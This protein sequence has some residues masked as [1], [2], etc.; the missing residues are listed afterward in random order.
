LAIHC[1][2]K[3][4][5]GIYFSEVFGFW[6]AHSSF[7]EKWMS[8]SETPISA[9]PADPYGTLLEMS[10]AM[11]AHTSVDELVRE[12]GR[13]LHNLLDF[14]YLTLMI[15][16]DNRDVMLTHTVHTQQPGPV[17]DP[18]YSMEQSPSA[19]VWRTQEPLVVGDLDQENR[20]PVVMKFFRQNGVRSFCIV[21]LTTATRRIG[22]LTFGSSHL[23]AYDPSDLE[24][25]CLVA[26]QVA[27][28]VENAINYQVARELQNDLLRERDRLKMLLDIN[29]AVTSNLGLAELLRAIASS[30]RTAIQ[31]DAAYVSMLE[32]N[33]KSLRVRGLDYPDPRG[34]L[35]EG[36]LIPMEGSISGRVFHS[37]APFI[38]GKVPEGLGREPLL[39]MQ[40]EQF[41]SGYFV[42][43][44]RDGRT[45]GLLH[46]AD[47]SPDFFTKADG[48]LLEQIARQLAIALDNALKYDEAQQSRGQIAEQARYL[49][50]ELRREHNF[51]E[52]LGDSAELRKV[53]SEVATVAPTGSTVLIQ[54]ETGTGKE[55]IARA[56]HNL[57][58]SRENI[59]VKLNCAAIPSGLL[60]SELFGHERGAFTGAIAQKKGRFELAD[61]GTLFLDEIGDIPLELQP[62]LLRV[63]QEQEFERLGSSHSIHV[64]VRLIAATN[65]DLAK[66]VEE[67]EFR[68]D[69]YYRLNV[70]PISL[71]P[72]RERRE[73]IPILAI[74]FVETFARRIGQPIHKVPDEVIESLK[75]YSWPGNIRELQN[76]IERAVILSKDG[77]LRTPELQKEPA[78]V[79][80]TTES[81]QSSDPEKPKTLVEA[82]REY[83]TQILRKANWVLSGRDGAAVKLGIPRTTL[84][85][86]MRQLGIPRRPE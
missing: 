48:E 20:Y 2:L 1:A 30:V 3:A 31:C 57:S 65:R 51:D 79:R 67:G 33:K 73:D 75:Q 23:R 83:I 43:I 86:K 77:V 66:M 17:A 6:P 38:F 42:P 9:I 78:A 24:L 72:L 63:L 37:G 32:R 80:L 82:E 28:A 81:R 34:A 8:F 47:R 53:L 27:V 62:K 44:Q 18:E 70:F 41:Q 49:R 68:A 71:P 12:L 14:T 52:I 39:L 25:P 69:L 35:A 54:G 26:A 16:D 10:R 85:Y 7:L 19:G 60:E 29:N 46:L 58:S 50:D 55:L 15:H 59:F 61:K 84:L 40:V 4:L 22:A 64:S 36:T 5:W 56:I 76:V 74:N 21:P 11:A 13:R 45:L